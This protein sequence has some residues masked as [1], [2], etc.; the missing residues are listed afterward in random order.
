MN[1]S[2]TEPKTS[3]GPE[4]PVEAAEA[5]TPPGSDEQSQGGEP[6]GHDIEQLQT[7]V[8]QL[9]T[10]VLRTA[11][12]FENYR[13]RSAREKEE[14]VRYANASLLRQLIPI[15]DNF[16]LGLE[17][18]AANPAA[19]DLVQGMK[20]V[21]KQ[22][23]ELLRNQNVDKIDAV[24]KPFDPNLHEAITQEAHPEIPEGHVFKQ[25]RPGYKMRDRLLRP[26]TVMVSSGPDSADAK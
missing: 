14:A 24:G 10:Q 5:Q 23:E 25:L 22:L 8:E 21:Q 4:Q 6:M 15:L 26:S 9:R 7:D 11:A 16:E 18:A 1:D 12:D 3:E 17:A 20:M 13:K 2:K 19:Q